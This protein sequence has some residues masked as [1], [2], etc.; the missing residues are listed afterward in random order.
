[1]DTQFL[2]QVTGALVQEGL[3]PFFVELIIERIFAQ[4]EI[5]LNKKYNWFYIPLAIISIIVLILHMTGPLE[6]QLGVVGF[7][8][9]TVLCVSII[10]FNKD[11]KGNIFGAI[12]YFIF[13][14]VAFL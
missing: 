8:L 1:V 11:S 6:G 5:S 7:A 13:G 12:L 10:V 9:F 14:L 3:T 4:G 2:I